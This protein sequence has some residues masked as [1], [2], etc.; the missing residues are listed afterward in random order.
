MPITINSKHNEQFA[1]QWLNNTFTNSILTKKKKLNRLITN[2]RQDLFNLQ[3]STDVKKVQN[4]EKEVN[5]VK[6]YLDKMVEMLGPS[7]IK[8]LSDISNLLAGKT[9]KELAQENN[10]LKSTDEQKT[11]TN[12]ENKLE[13]SKGELKK[14]KE[15]NNSLLKIQAKLKDRISTSLVSIEALIKNIDRKLV[16]GEKDIITQVKIIQDLLKEHD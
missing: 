9:L 16:K 5:K 11:I 6:S 15:E 8:N 1:G 12:L 7:E 2:L 13:D 3:N 10:Q 4:L 14:Y